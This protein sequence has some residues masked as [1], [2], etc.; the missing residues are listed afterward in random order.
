[1]IKVALVY[2]NLY[3]VGISNLGFHIVYDLANSLEYVSCERFFLDRNLSIETG[4]KLG[5]FDII[6]FSWQFELD[7]LNILE[8]LHRNGI[9][10]RRNERE[11]IVAVGGP[12][13]VNPMPLKRF[14]DIFFIGEA[15]VNLIP[16]LELYAEVGKDIE[17]FTDIDGI[18][19]SDIDNKVK[20]VYFRNLDDYYPRIAEAQDSSFGDTFLLE[21][22]RGCNRGCRFCMGG[23]IFRPK[24][25]RSLDKLK[26]IVDRV[27]KK[28]ICLLGASVSDYTNI[29]ELCEY[30]SSRNFLISAPSLRADT[31]TEDMVRYLVKSGQ[32]SI[33]LAPEANERLRRVVNKNISD[34][35]IL[36]ACDICFRAGIKNFKLY[37]ILGIPTEDEEDI[38]EEAELVKKIKGKI[39]L[40]INPLIPKPHTPFQWIGLDSIS[41]VKYKVKLLRKILKGRAK[42]E[43]EN[44][45]KSFLQATISRGDE[46]L[47]EIIEKAFFY[48]KGLGA[49]RRAFK[50]CN[51]EYGHYTRE[52]SLDEELP[53]SKIGI[54]ISEK[55][56]KSEYKKALGLI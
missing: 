1:M 52:L 56:L 3:R 39:K 51:M 18:Y 7:C 43:V 8:I 34:E 40:S 30:L 9:P 35:Q 49:F 25:E 46:K 19:V 21:I 53:W 41:N 28:K 29:E 2:P 50:E 16:F 22:S 27:K 10:I 6:L 15:E 45:K 48:G 14:V 20:R 47:G 31:L 26:E 24:R 54:G 33:T 17:S 42:I 55:F 44:L 32:R 4:A 13:S 23:Y 5:D 37:F 11:Q 36:R 38:K 12:C